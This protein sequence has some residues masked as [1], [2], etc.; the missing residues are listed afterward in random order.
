MSQKCTRRLFLAS[1]A[2]AVAAAGCATTGT[3]T[4]ARST[5]LAKSGYKSANEKLNIAGIGVGGKGSSDISQ[6]D[7]ENVVALADVDWQKGA[8]AFRRF[9]NAKKYKDFRRM[10]DEMGNEIDACTIST[11][12]HLHAVAAMRC[13]ERGIHVY[14]QKPI[15][16]TVHEARVMTEAARKYG[17]VTQMGNQGEASAGRRLTCELIWSG[18]IGQVREVHSWTNRPIWPQGIPGPLP[19][20]T[21]PDHV[22]WDL[23][24]GPAPF[25]PYNSGYAPFKWRG[26]WDF[27]CGALGDMACH[28]LNPVTK[29]LQ[30][31]YP[32]SIECIH[33]K[34][35]ND[36]TFPTESILRY[37]FPQRGGFSP[38]TVY[39]YDGKLKPKLTQDIDPAIPLCRPDSGS[40]FVGD[41]GIMEIP[42]NGGV[43]HVIIDGKKV[44][45]YETPQ[46]ILPRL[47]VYANADGKGADSDRM[48]KID[49]IRGIK[50][51]SIPGSN[52]DHA[53]P[54]TEWVVLGNL[55]VRFPHTKL[56]WDG[57][58]M[59]FTNH[60]EANRYVSKKYRK[61]WAL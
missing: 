2:A 8:G 40:I 59:R 13:M 60:N 6:C 28:I 33:Q 25:R 42:Q 56:E 45:D 29:S 26:W 47:P 61:G 38:V 54:L 24:I 1:S 17:V 44:T 15:S 10:L 12:D 7:M 9:S 36:Q 52:F 35:A 19:E 18:I 50:T 5:T 14:V 48:H 32:T 37:T 49:W 39:W 27:G 43:T 23:W 30:L 22:D 46:E 53:G 4:S 20:E 11:P 58:R 21:V 34:G 31:G 41:K 57:P 16:H 51:G 3:K 55:S